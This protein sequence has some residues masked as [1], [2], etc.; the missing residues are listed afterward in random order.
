M[1][2]RLLNQ[3]PKATK[4]KGFI[5]FF[6]LLFS[7]QSFAD[8]TYC[9]QI[10]GF[11]FS[12]GNSSISITDGGEYTLSQLPNNFYVDVIVDGHSESSSIRVKNLDTSQEVTIGENYLPY[13]FPAGNGAWN[14][15]PGTY[16]V[17]AKIFKYNYCQGWSCDTETITFSL[18]KN[19]SCGQIDGFKFANGTD[20]LTIVDGELYDINSIP[21]NFNIHIQAS[22]MTESVSNTLTNLD[23]GAVYTNIEN[24]LPY[25]FPGATNQVWTLGCGTFRLCSNVYKYDNANGNE[26]DSA[27]ITFTLTGCE[28]PCG[29]I[30]EFQFANGTD[31][32][33]SILDGETYNINDLPADFYINGFV[34]GDSESFRYRVTNTD[35]GQVYN[36]IENYL[37]YTFPA[38]G[39]AWFLGTGTFEVKGE[40]FSG[41]Y[42]S[43]NKCDELIITFT[44]IE[45]DELCLVNT[46]TT[47]VDNTV[48]LLVPNTPA[49]VV[50]IIPGDDTVL[51]P[52]EN[53]N[54][55]CVLSQGENKTISAFERGLSIQLLQPG[56]FNVHLLVFDE[57]T[58]D[59]DTIVLGQT[60]VQDVLDT[61]NNNEVCAS[62]DGTGVSILAING[63]ADERA[64]NVKVKVKENVDLPTVS[65]ILGNKTEEVDSS[66]EVKLYPNPVVN[67]LNVELLLLDAEIMNYNMYDL[68]GRQVLSGSFDNSTLGKTQVNVKTLSTG[69]Y[70]LKFESNFR[71]FSKKVQIKK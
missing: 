55:A 14:Y 4:L 2:K 1:K 11:E 20:Y 28:E 53:A 63:G 10:S 15:G 8:E 47:A 58:L 40:L 30:T 60:T 39:G 61:I 62:I 69:L 67:N 41:N 46:G 19:P 57:T 68:N 65:T 54:T 38:G 51:V 16:Q 71:T 29:T 35:T 59:L 49:P 24:V 42:C 37:D 6:S 18:V 43:Y 33:T 31:A 23:T 7:M 64:A 48:F 34:S 56:N 3:T 52:G 22:G 45:E 9:G 36:I 12:N 26:C 50:N 44:L 21:S 66:V 70:I 27:C 32:S 25:T 13:T 5:L 17:K